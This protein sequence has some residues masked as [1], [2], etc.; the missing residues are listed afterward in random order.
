MEVSSSDFDEFWI[1][2]SL[3]KKIRDFFFYKSL[4]ALLEN[5]T[6]LWRKSISQS[7]KSIRDV[8]KLFFINKIYLNKF[9][10]LL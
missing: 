10:K 6:S 4:I 9:L 3:D 1:C 8:S 5:T 2:C 7:V